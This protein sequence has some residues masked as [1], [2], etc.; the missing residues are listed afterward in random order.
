MDGLTRAIMTGTVVGMF[1]L[2]TRTQAA[3][4]FAGRRVASFNA[5]WKFAKGPQAGAE[6]PAFDDSA[7]QAV[8]LPH[9]WAI[10]GPFNPN[11]NGYAGKLPWRGEGWYRK[12][13]TLDKAAPGS[14][15]YFDFDGVMAF[16][17]V[18]VNGQLAGQWDYGYMSFRVDVTP[19]VKFG[20]KNVVAVHAD[21]RNHGT[22]WYPGA[23]I[24][25]K[26]TIT[27]CNPVHVAHWG[28]FVT[29]PS[30][31]DASATVRVQSTIENHQD[32]PAQAAVEIAV[33]DPA[34]K[35]VATGLQPAQVALPAGG[36]AA[37]DQSFTIPNPQRWDIAT[38][39]RYA[40]KVTVRLGDRVV[41]A[42][43][44]PF[45]VRTFE[46]TAD[47][48]FHLNGR[49]VQLFGVNLHHDHGP[50]GAAFYT[51]AMQRQLE[52]MK[53]M[54]VNSL[55]TSHNPPSSEVL[56][57]CDR[58]GIVVWDEAF[59]KWEG[60][61]DRVK[62]EPPLEQHG[63]RQ[64]RNLVMRDRN[65]PSVVVWSIGNEIGGGGRDGVTPERV[66]F[67]SDFVRKY[68]S[69][70]PVGMGCH[71]PELARGSNFD[72]L[73][74]TGWNYMR[75]YSIFRE[76][77]PDKPIVYSESASALSTRGFYELPLP[78]RK[79]EYSDQLQ[80]NSYDLNAADW[81]DIPDVEFKLMQDD[82]FVAGEMVW[83]GFDYL[84]EPT[85][86]SQE[87]K[88]SYFGIVDLAGIPKD[89][90]Y[91]YRSHWR[92]DATT[93]HILPH[94]NWP[95]RV[96]QEVPVF[97]YTNGDSAELFLN[98]KSL[99]RRQKGVVPQGPP[100]YAKGKPAAASS[101]QA[102]HPA[103]HAG[104]GDKNTRWCA[105]SADPNQWWQVD[106]GQTQT[107][108][109]L[110]IDFE[111]EEKNYGYEVR[112]S[113]DGQTWETIV[114]KPTSRN[115]RWGGPTQIFHDVDATGRYLRIAF[116][117]LQDNVWASIREFAAYPERAESE[118]YAPTYTYRL[119]WNEVVYEPGELKA[120]AYKDGR[121]IGEAVMRTAEEPAALRLT[122]D[123]TQ[124]AATGEDLCYVLVEAFDKKGT[125]CPLAENLVRFQVEGPAEIAGVGNGNP[126]SI[127]PFQAD[128][129]EL[130]YGKAMLILRTQP[131]K[132]GKVKVTASAEGLKPGETTVTAQ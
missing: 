71:I 94:W 9:D 48:G 58:M 65:H 70:R 51:R 126:L 47:D 52:I 29:T 57:L 132:T 97:V 43:L 33:T 38:P 77:Y 4:V 125:P 86:F 101:S 130:F 128:H 23:G 12:A 59:D 22:R 83:T 1:V 60:T 114:A 64:I 124:L 80:V 68:D 55:R 89:R 129:R 106:L 49:R 21:T 85:P 105:A 17:K 62:G 32:K 108:R 103:Q 45:G 25:R 116:N 11:E 87:A 100:N 5:D 99:G 122:P 120:V 31:D 93:V 75:R 27:I 19:Y 102:E 119:R 74:L 3:E 84:G 40:V 69:T 39:R 78:N 79:N 73:D 81:S 6:D 7:W 92:P 44:V 111:R 41:D 112:I 46:F 20:D 37:F 107:V 61:A 54:G 13:F 117:Q 16:P 8:R 67:M 91:L 115:P 110:A 10:A 131:G 104:E 76:R 95:D 2:A 63:E 35:P 14:R 56:E 82:P 98:G 36:E 121:K 123:R 34:G 26:V 96:G 127:E 72:A 50:L 15:V 88:S 66:K 24:Y 30:V 113:S 109:Y 53:D 18:Y 118:Y 28:T 42:D 90:F